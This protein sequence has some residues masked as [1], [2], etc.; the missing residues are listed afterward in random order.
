MDIDQFVARQLAEQGIEV[1]PEEAGRHAREAFANIR[2][3]MRAK[4]HQVP[5]DDRE[6]AALISAARNYEPAPPLSDEKYRRIWDN[7][8]ARMDAE[9]RPWNWRCQYKSFKGGRAR[10]FRVFGFGI[11]IARDFPLGRGLHVGRYCIRLL[12]PWR[13]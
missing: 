5:D 2:A 4:G 9:P 3:A 8:Q 1:T 6:L 12:A 13:G 7:L 11:R 10:W